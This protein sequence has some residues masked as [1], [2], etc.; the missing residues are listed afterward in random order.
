M[1]KTLKTTS[2]QGTNLSTAF[3]AVRCGGDGLGQFQLLTS[4]ASRSEE[5]GSNP[6]RDLFPK[7]PRRF[8]RIKAKDDVER[9][10][11]CESDGE[12]RAQ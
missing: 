5:G 4:D 10:Y 9:L 7:V 11:E 2:Q 12:Q 1:E 6:N 8:D 3:E